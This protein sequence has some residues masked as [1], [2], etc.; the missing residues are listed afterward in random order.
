MPQDQKSSLTEN[1]AA[2]IAVGANAAPTAPADS[3][4]PFEEDVAD[5]LR[6][7]QEVQPSPNLWRRIKAALVGR[8]GAV[9]CENGGTAET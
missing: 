8:P 7:A 1:S 6:G 3:T 9:P 2:A 5:L 4:D